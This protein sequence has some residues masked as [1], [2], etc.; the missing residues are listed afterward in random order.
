MFLA[1]QSHKVA[2]EN[3]KNMA[4]AVI[5]QAPS[6]TPVVGQGEVFDDVSCFR[7]RHC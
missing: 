7:V 6:P 2:V 4:A 1:R 3:Q 5:R